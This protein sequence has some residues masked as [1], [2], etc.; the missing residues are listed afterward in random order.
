VPTEPT[1]APTAPTNATYSSISITAPT[2][3]TYSSISITAPILAS[4]FTATAT[5][6]AFTAFPS[7]PAAATGATAATSFATSRPGPASLHYGVHDMQRPWR[8]IFARRL[9]LLWKLLPG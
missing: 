5:F 7:L 4:N 9:E 1:E 2:N 8:P 6:S 3:A